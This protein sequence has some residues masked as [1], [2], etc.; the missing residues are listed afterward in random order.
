AGWVAGRC[1]AENLAAGEFTGQRIDL[2]VRRWHRRFG[3][4]ILSGQFDRT[5]KYGAGEQNDGRGTRDDPRIHDRRPLSV[6]HLHGLGLVALRAGEEPAELLACLLL[7][8]GGASA[9]EALRT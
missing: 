9:S 2:V 1:G 6:E 3:C 7:I 5:G 8:G 4:A